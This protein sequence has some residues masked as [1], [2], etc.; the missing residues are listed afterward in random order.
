M[1]NAKVLAITGTNGKTTTKE[2]IAAIMSKKYK[3]HYTKG[4][5][6]NE[7]GLPMTILSA[8]GDVEMMVLEMGA[9][10]LGEIR[11]LCNIARPDYGIITNIGNAHIEGFGS[12]EGVLKAKSELYEYL[13][14]VKDRYQVGYE[15]APFF[16][17]SGV[18]ENRAYDPNFS[19]INV[20]LRN[21]E[22]VDVTKASGRLALQYLAEPTRKFYLCYPKAL[23]HHINTPTF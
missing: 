5:L 10:H 13:S 15:D 18:V 22:S 4:N 17:A 20:I 7:I 2:L 19:T 21:G 6:N 11:T 23:D 14:K 9:N 3:V 16:I 1:T 12:F 8:P